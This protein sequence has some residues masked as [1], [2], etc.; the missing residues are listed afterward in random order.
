MSRI[1][2]KMGF[3]LIRTGKHMIFEH[4]NGRTTS[5]PNHPAEEIGPGL[6]KKIISE[7]LKIS[8]EEFESYL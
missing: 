3:T 1:L 6:L 2:N 8:R 4:P 5:I 7:D